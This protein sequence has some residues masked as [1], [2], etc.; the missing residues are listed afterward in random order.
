MKL[1]NI[2]ENL[3]KMPG[4]YGINKIEDIHFILFGGN[5]FASDEIHLELEEFQSQFKTYINNYFKKDYKFEGD[6]DW[7]R[8]IRLYSFSDKNSIEMFGELFHRFLSNNG[9]A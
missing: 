7:Y 8:L 5:L 6:Y 3:I 9:K 1:Y 4:M 2:I